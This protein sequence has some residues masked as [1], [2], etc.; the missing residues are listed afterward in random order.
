MRSKKRFTLTLVVLAIA[1]LC[2]VVIASTVG[3]IH[4]PALDILKMSL[5][6]TSL[7]HFEPTWPKM[8]ETI[9]F[10]IRLPRVLAGALVGAALSTTVS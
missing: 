5:N 9:I 4:V 10:S 8:H 6:K 7:F 3:T 2:C 1:L